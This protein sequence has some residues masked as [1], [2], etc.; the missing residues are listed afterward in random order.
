MT[1]G[2]DDDC[3][4]SIRYEA[5]TDKA[6]HC[7]MTNH[8]YFNLAGCTSGSIRD[9]I[10]TVDADAITPVSDKGAHSDGRIYAR[11]GYAV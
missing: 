10:L 4:L 3:N 6:T 7:N 1:Y 5:T 2:W 9:H 8:T 11:G